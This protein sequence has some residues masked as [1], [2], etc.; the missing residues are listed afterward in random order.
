MAGSPKKRT[1]E[2][3]REQ[4]IEFCVREVGNARQPHHAYIAA[5]TSAAHLC[6][7]ISREAKKAAERRAA[8][9]CGDFI[10]AVADAVK[11]MPD[12]SGDHAPE[13]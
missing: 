10:W 13:V 5:L 12:R 4:M 6:D 2:Q 11:A 9:D 3:I 7:Q 8:K 1:P